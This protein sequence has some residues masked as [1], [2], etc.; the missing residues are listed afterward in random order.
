MFCVFFYP[1]KFSVGRRLPKAMI[2]FRIVLDC[3]RE[4]I[5]NINSVVTTSKVL[6]VIEVEDDI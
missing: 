2:T 4:V 6:S 5:S 3:L 1:E